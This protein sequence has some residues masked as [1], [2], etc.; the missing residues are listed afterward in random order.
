MPTAPTRSLALR[1]LPRNAPVVGLLALLAA[2]TGCTSGSAAG[3]TAVVEVPTPLAP[4]LRPAEV[5]PAPD[6]VAVRNAADAPGAFAFVEMVDTRGW[7]ALDEA[8][9][10]VVGSGPELRSDPATGFTALEAKARLAALDRELLLEGRSFDLYEGETRLCTVRSGPVRILGVTSTPF[11]N[12]DE[13]AGERPATA[14]DLWSYTR[15]FVAL[16]FDVP[17]ECRK[18]T[19]ARLSELP[20]PRFARTREAMVDA[21]TTEREAQFRGAP[22]WRELQQRFDEARA[23]GSTAATG[24]WDEAG[25]LVETTWLAPGTSASWTVRQAVWDE[26]CGATGAL[27]LAWRDDAQGVSMIYAA[28]ER[29]AI[30]VVLDLDGDGRLE[31]IGSSWGGRELRPFFGTGEGTLRAY[32]VPEHGCPC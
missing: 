12:I 7:I 31:M 13:G 26:G 23:S 28:E 15:R 30:D 19:W 6:R 21:A 25:S 29:F 11:E 4:P 9:D 22:A 27:T 1:S 2:A 24:M 16:P 14:A 17:A 5:T 8:A 32:T 10:E 18:A 20:E 3:P